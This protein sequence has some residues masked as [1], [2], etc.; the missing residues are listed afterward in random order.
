MARLDDLG[1]GDRPLDSIEVVDLRY[2]GMGLLPLLFA[3]KAWLQTVARNQSRD[4]TLRRGFQ[5][6][7]P[8]GSTTPSTGAFT[9]LSASST[10]TLSP[11]SAAVAISPTGTGTVAISPVGA[12]TINPTAASTINN[13]SIGQTTAAA[14]TFTTVNKLTLTHPLLERRYALLKA[15]AEA[16]SKRPPKF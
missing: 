1:T 3:R 2:W 12:L 8:I 9:T 5:A 10:V 15:K 14:G 4:E 16:E 11:A 7:G 6:P 13:T